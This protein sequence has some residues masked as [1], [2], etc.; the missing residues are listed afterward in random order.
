MGNLETIT[1]E[2]GVILGPGKKGNLEVVV[3]DASSRGGQWS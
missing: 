2:V 3:V 1:P